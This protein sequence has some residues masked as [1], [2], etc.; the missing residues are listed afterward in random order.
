M[1][2]DFN[3]FFIILFQT[4]TIFGVL[5][6]V[7]RKNIFSIFDPLF[8]YLIT[9]AFSIEL[10]II[11]ITDVGYLVSF[12]LCQFFF[13]I[14]FNCL[15]KNLKKDNIV[16]D[17]KLVFSDKEYK[18]WFYFTVFGFLIVVL[19]N[20]YLISMQGII[21]FSD[22]PTTGKV[23]A[24]E[25][26]GGI[27]AVRRI[28]WGLLNLV[29]LSA[30]FLY[31]KTKKKLFLIIL[32]VLILIAVSG[33]AKSSLLVYIVL[34]AFLG[35]FK[36]INKTKVFLIINKIKIPLIVG[37]LLLSIFIIGANTDGLGDSI[38][39]LGIRFLYF[40]DILFYYYNPDAVAHF[41]Q[42]GIIDFLNYELNPFL[43]IL[44]ISPYLPPLSFQMVQYSFSHN[45]VL[46]VVTGPNLPYYVKGHIFFGKYG[47]LF[48]S[49]L[50]GLFIAYIRNLIFVKHSSYTI[51]LFWIFINL[52]VF[53]FAQDSTLTLSIFF[54]TLIFSLCPIFVALI[55]IYSPNNVRNT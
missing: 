8:Y 6:L 28:N 24:F 31:L 30:L 4:V 41:Q 43:G 12:L 10:G 40:G 26:G 54:D 22:D 32:F 50:L 45:E 9:Q 16:D 3:Q 29:N 55:L 15:A 48:Y 35:Q 1:I 14:G 7:Y 27:G 46:D 33:G 49:F 37:G 36:T 20:L 39:G 34:L 17:S 38:L 5:F 23:A 25:G 19:A 13:A 53:S 21:L 47:A 18:F 11:Q 2:N 52:S 51:Y 44:R 42:L